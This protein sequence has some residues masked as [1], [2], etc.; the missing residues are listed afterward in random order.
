MEKDKKTTTYDGYP[1]KYTKEQNARADAYMAKL[2]PALVK[3]LNSIK[4]G[5]KWGKPSDKTKA[6]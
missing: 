3:S 4:E 6:Q 5:G 1:P 2:G